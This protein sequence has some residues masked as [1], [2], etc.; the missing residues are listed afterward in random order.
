MC[1]LSQTAT[2]CAPSL[3]S[4]DLRATIGDGP[5]SSIPSL[6][7]QE[8]W[9]SLVQPQILCVVGGRYFMCAHC[10]S[11]SPSVSLNSLLE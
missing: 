5:L 10:L 9:Q 8:V 2:C 11:E 6:L 1:H 7:L 3:P 4:L